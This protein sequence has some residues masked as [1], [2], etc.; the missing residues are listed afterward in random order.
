M[1]RAAV[2][3]RVRPVERRTRS[4]ACRIPSGRVSLLSSPVSESGW[5]RCDRMLF[6]EASFSQSVGD[7][8]LAVR[9]LRRKVREA[10]VGCVLPQRGCRGRT[11]LWGEGEMFE[12]GTEAPAAGIGRSETEAGN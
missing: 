7:S 4:V 9:R 11:T 6:P 5:T 2:L 1:L 10:V 3:H 12:K 8:C